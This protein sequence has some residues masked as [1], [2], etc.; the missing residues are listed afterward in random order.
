M[1]RCL[2]LVAKDAN[3]KAKH[4]RKV[5][6]KL[7]TVSIYYPRA[8]LCP[9]HVLLHFTHTHTHTP[10]R[11]ENQLPLHASGHCPYIIGGSAPEPLIL[12]SHLILNSYFKHPDYALTTPLVNPFETEPS[13]NQAVSKPSL[14]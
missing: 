5:I 6:R 12:D 3:S 11:K 8:S 13:L 4:G 7:A 1:D 14:I 9:S 2:L 10:R